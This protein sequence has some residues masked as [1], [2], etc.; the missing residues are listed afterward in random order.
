MRV[1]DLSGRVDHDLRLLAGLQLL[2]H[3]GGRHLAGLQS[4]DQLQVV[5]QGA[6]GLVQQPTHMEEDDGGGAVG[7]GGGD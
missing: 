6:A 3:L 5:Q 4:V 2:R 1:A 7:G